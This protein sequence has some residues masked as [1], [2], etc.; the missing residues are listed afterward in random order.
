[1]TKHIIISALLVVVTFSVSAQGLYDVSRYANT[2][3][4]GTARYMSLAGSMGAIG[5]DP[6]A[7][8]DNPGALG[9]YRSSEVSF[10]L[11]ATPSV[12]FAKSANFYNRERD[13]F[14]NFNQLTFV[15][16]IP[17]GK[18]EG[19]VSTNFSFSYNRLK[20]FN[21]TVSVL[22]NNTSS[23]GNALATLADGFAPSNLVEEN[24]FAPYLPIL[25]YQGYAINTLETDSFSYSPYSN[26]TKQMGYRGI[27]NG[28]IDE[29]NLT[30]AANIGHYL[31][32][33]VGLGVQT[34]HYS[35]TSTN[36]ESYDVGLYALENRFVASGVGAVVR[37][38]LIARPV[39]F[40]RL[41]LSFQSPVWYSM[42]DSY[43]GSATSQGILD[44]HSNVDYSTP[45]AGSD[46][47]FNSPL[48]VQASLGFVIGKTA[49][50]NVDYQYSHNKGMRL[51]D[52]SA[53]SGI[54]STPMF[55]FENNDIRQNALNSHLVKVGA[56]F[57]IAQR[58]SIRAGA[59]YETQ[60]IVTG[61]ARYLM[62]N[63]TRTDMEMFADRGTIYAAG[64]FGYRYN[65]FGI[66]ITYAY[67]RHNQVFAP[68]QQNAVVDNGYFGPTA[69]G[70][71]PYLADIHTN[72]HNVV[73]TLLYKF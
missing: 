3:I 45:R 70:S 10:T 12:T 69:N 35:F 72:R 25:G 17:S 33:G 11:N 53:N 29:Y 50:I 54:F 5:G 14:F 57:R 30:Y 24:A 9:I 22:D 28:R 66:D 46:Y 60:N 20:D 47:D 26:K 31:Y 15:L 13:F 41:G 51:I 68:F 67:N 4:M 62:D 59:A 7:I 65:G 1:M 58:F 56:E 37:V 19:Y 34:L 39:S 52:K 18:D 73:L 44:D 38:G 64:G 71:T 40:L 55:D 48:K 2:D 42:T 8:F 16:A 32:F 21:R 6:S 43:K 63:T 61:A 23:M 27:E 49:L 36:A